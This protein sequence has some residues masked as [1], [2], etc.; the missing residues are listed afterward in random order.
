MYRVASICEWS[1]RVSLRAT[2]QQVHVP[3]VIP[4]QLLTAECRKQPF[5][6]QQSEA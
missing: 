4:Y 2:G 3:G 5:G 6:K 1:L